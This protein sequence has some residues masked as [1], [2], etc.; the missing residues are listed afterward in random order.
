M[1][2]SAFNLIT[3]MH[4]RRIMRWNDHRM[5]IANE[6]QMAYRNEINLMMTTE[7]E[8]MF[9]LSPFHGDK[10]RQEAETFLAQIKI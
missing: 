5:S 6:L 8:K 2:R 7:S 10:G 1:P 9:K 3:N 4:G